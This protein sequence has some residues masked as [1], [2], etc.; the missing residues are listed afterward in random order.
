MTLI[1]A[2]TVIIIAGIA[3]ETVKAILAHRD[4]SSV[5]ALRIHALQ[6][7]TVPLEQASVAIH[8][9]VRLAADPALGDEY[10]ERVEALVI[11][12][13]ANGSLPDDADTFRPEP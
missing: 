3:A 10:L 1:I 7:D 13:L 9:A 12:E 8:R 6:A 5:E 2:G 4:E 11:D